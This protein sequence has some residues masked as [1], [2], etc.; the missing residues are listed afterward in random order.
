MM[1]LEVC[2]PVPSDLIATTVDF[3]AAGFAGTVFTESICQPF[4]VGGAYTQL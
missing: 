1:G 4:A 3:E 2:S